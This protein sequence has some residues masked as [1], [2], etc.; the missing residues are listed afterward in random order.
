VT[1]HWPSVTADRDIVASNGDHIITLA[2]VVYTWKGQAK[3]LKAT[4]RHKDRPIALRKSRQL[5]SEKVDA[6]RDKQE[7]AAIRNARRNR[8]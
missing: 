2:T 3:T 6:H 8:K 4:A 5:L 7:K 1:N